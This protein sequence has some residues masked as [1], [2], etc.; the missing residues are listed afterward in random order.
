MILTSGFE[1]YLFFGSMF[2]WGSC[3]C[4]NEYYSEKFLEEL[5]KKADEI[6]INYN[7]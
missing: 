4:L 2:A 6:A 3:N 5:K 1:Y 7:I